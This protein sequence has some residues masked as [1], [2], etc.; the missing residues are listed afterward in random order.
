MTHTERKLTAGDL[1]AVFLPGRGMLG[2]SLR[3]RGEEF[4][5]RLENLDAAAAKGSTVGIPFLY[6]WANRLAVPCFR[7]AGRDVAL[8][9][10][11]PLLHR[12]DR[13]LLIHGV[14]WALLRGRSSRLSPT[15]SPPGWVG[16]TRSYWQFFRSATKSS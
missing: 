6:P 1:E 16:R 4:L 5:R 15:V 14:K 8:D 7:V 9:P 2:V 12:D 13:G 11:S 10:S 3:L